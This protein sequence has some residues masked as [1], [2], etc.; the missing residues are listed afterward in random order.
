MRRVDDLQ[1]TKRDLLPCRNTG[2]VAN[3]GESLPNAPSLGAPLPITP[4]KETE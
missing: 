1:R 4:T 3:V 2:C